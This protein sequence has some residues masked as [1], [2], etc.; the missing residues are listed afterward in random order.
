MNGPFKNIAV[1]AAAAGAMSCVS[2]LEVDERNFETVDFT[3]SVPTADGA[4]TRAQDDEGRIVQLDVLQFVGGRF[5]HRADP[6]FDNIVQTGGSFTFAVRMMRGAGQD[7][8]VVANARRSVDAAAAGWNA[9][10]DMQTALD[11]LKMGV[12][13]A[14]KLS[15]GGMFGIKKGVTIDETTDFTGPSGTIRLVRMVAKIELQLTTLAATGAGSNADAYTGADNSNFR[16]AQVLLYNQP[17]EGWVVPETATWNG[18]GSAW[19][20]GAAAPAKAIYPA[21][22]P[23]VYATGA[24]ELRNS[25]YLFEAPAGAP[26]GQ[27]AYLRNTCVVM[28]GHYRGGAQLSYYRLDLRD[29]AGG[30]PALLRNNNYIVRVQSVTGAGC[31]NPHDAF[32]NDQ[33]NITAVVEGWTDRYVDAGL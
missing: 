14:Q 10:T 11:E 5:A 24:N 6:G 28:A 21:D 8:V 32:E 16:L 9:S 20:G 3:I 1:V 2:G 7:V 23:L 19:F 30:Y 4:S 33:S 12:G 13:A 18:S 27:D 29:S 17:L 15:A 31:D 22:Q 25:I 26:K